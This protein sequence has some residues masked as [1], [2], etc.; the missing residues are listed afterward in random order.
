MGHGKKSYSNGLKSLKHKKSLLGGG[1]RP[2][3]VLA[4]GSGDSDSYRVR[5]LVSLREPEKA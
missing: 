3:L 4:P 2:N 1:D 5:A